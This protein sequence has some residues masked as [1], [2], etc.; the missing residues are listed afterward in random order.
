MLRGAVD[1]DVLSSG[2]TQF[3]PG[4][5]IVVVSGQIVG[6]ALPRHQFEVGQVPAILPVEPALLAQPQTN[7]FLFA[8]PRRAID[9]LEGGEAKIIRGRVLENHFLARV[10]LHLLRRSQQR[11]LGRLVRLDL[12][13]QAAT[14]P[15]S[16]P[17]YALTTKAGGARLREHKSP[18]PPSS[19][20]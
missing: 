16:P 20:S 8:H 15:P 19:P 18:V 11:H 7:A 12:D 1:L 6:D 3:L 14:P 13:P 5:F 4:D 10:D 17:R 9:E 2:N